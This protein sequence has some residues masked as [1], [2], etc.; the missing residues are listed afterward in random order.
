MNCELP[1]NWRAG[2]AVEKVGDWTEI[3]TASL[4]Y[5]DSPVASPALPYAIEL[6]DLPEDA[7]NVAITSI[8]ARWL[9][10]DAET[11]LAPVRPVAEP[12]PV[13]QPV[14]IPAP[15]PESYN[16][17][18][19]PAAEAELSGG[20]FDKGRFR[21]RIRFNPYRYTHSTLLLERAKSIKVTLSYESDARPRVSVMSVDAPPAATNM[22]IVSPPAY[23][24]LW[25][26]YIAYRRTTHPNI[27]ISVKNTADIYK[28]FPDAVAADDHA[29]AIHKFLEA[30]Y[31]TN[32]LKIVILGACPP[33]YSMDVAYSLD[34]FKAG[35]QKL[36]EEYHVPT[37][38]PSSFLCRIEEPSDLYFGCMDKNDGKEVWDSNGDHMYFAKADKNGIFVWEDNRDKYADLIPEL[39]VC[40]VSLTKE[41][42]ETSGGNVYRYTAAQQMTN[43]VEKIKY[44]ESKDWKGEGVHGLSGDTYFMGEGNVVSDLY[45]E[46][47]EFYDGA[48]NMGDAAFPKHVI[49]NEAFIR[50]RNYDYHTGMRASKEPVV[51]LGYLNATDGLYGGE[52]FGRAALVSEREARCA[53]HSRDMENAVV[54]SHGWMRSCNPWWS[55]G[56]MTGEISGKG[57]LLY[58]P[59]PCDSGM[60]DNSSITNTCC[61][62]VAATLAPSGFAASCGNTRHGWWAGFDNSYNSA[63]EKY[64]LAATFGVDGATDSFDAA[65]DAQLRPNSF[66]EA[67]RLM[68]KKYVEQYGVSV[69]GTHQ[70]ISLFEMTAFGDPLMSLTPQ[71]D[72]SDEFTRT[73]T[74][75]MTVTQNPTVSTTSHVARLVVESGA[76]RIATSDAGVLRVTAGA[77]IKGGSLDWAAAGGI[78][79]SIAFANPGGALTVSA[80]KPSYIGGEFTNVG[81]VKVTGKN[82]TIDFGV[83]SVNMTMPVDSLSF[84]SSAAGATNTLRNA[85]RTATSRFTDKTI[86]VTNSTLKCELTTAAPFSLKNSTLLVERNPMWRNVSWNE[87]LTMDDSTFVNAFDGFSFAN[88]ATINAIGGKNAIKDASGTGA[89]NVEGDL[90]VNLAAGAELTVECALQNL[91]THDSTLVV[92]GAGKIK[93]DVLPLKGF[94]SVTIGSGVTIEIPSAVKGR[95]RLIEGGTAAEILLLEGSTVVSGGVSK[96]SAS[97]FESYIFPDGHDGIPL[98]PYRLTLSSSSV[99]WLDS[100]DWTDKDGTKF[101]QSWRATDTVPGKTYVELDSETKECVLE[102][103]GEVEIGE[104]YITASDTGSS[105]AIASSGEF[106]ASYIDATG[107]AGALTLDCNLDS[108]SSTSL[109]AGP[110]TRFLGKGG[111]GRLTIGA[112]TKATLAKGWSGIVDSAG[113][114]VCEGGTSAD[115]AGFVPPASGMVVIAAPLAPGKDCTAAPEFTVKGESGVFDLSGHTLSV[116][117]AME[118]LDGAKLV[119]SNLTLSAGA[120]TMRID[121]GTLTLGGR[122]GA[123]DGASLSVA[124]SNGVFSAYES[125]SLDSDS[126]M[127]LEIVEGAK[128]T[129]DTAGNSISYPGVISGS[130]ALCVTNSASSY[131]TLVLGGANTYSGGTAIGGDL[132]VKA[133]GSGAFG[134]AGLLVL[135]EGVT[136]ELGSVRLGG[137]VKLDSSSKGTVTIALTEPEFSAKRA[138]LMK[139]DQAPE[140]M[141]FIAVS[142]TGSQVVGNVSVE[143]GNLVYGVESNARPITGKI[144]ENTPWTQIKWED[145]NGVSL[146]L[147][148]GQLVDYGE[149]RLVATVPGVF[150]TLDTSDLPERIV[151]GGAERLGMS[152]GSVADSSLPT[153]TIEEGTTVLF[154]DSVDWPTGKLVN[155]GIVRLVMSSQHTFTVG[156]MVSGRNAYS[157][158]KAGAQLTGSSGK[159]LRIEDGDAITVKD[160][161]DHD[162]GVEM[163]G[164]SILFDYYLDTAWIGNLSLNNSWTQSGGTA[165]FNFANPYIF[166]YPNKYGLLLGWTQSG[167][168]NVNI[169]GGN[170]NIPRSHINFW[171][172]GTTMTVSGMGVVNAGGILANG[173]GGRALNIRDGGEVR[174]GSLGA[175]SVS[176]TVTIDGGALVGTAQNTP[177]NCAI[178]VKDATLAATAGATLKLIGGFGTSSGTI[179][180][181][182]DNC[183]GTVDIGTLRPVDLVLSAS[184]L[185]TLRFTANTSELDR[186]IELFKAEDATLP[187]ALQVVCVDENGVE[188]YG[189][190]S[191]Y[192][193][194]IIFLKSGVLPYVELDGGTETLDG[195]TLYTEMGGKTGYEKWL[196]D[197]SY[198]G[199]KNY[200][201]EKLPEG[202][203]AHIEKMPSQGIRLVLMTLKP[204]TMWAG[205]FR[206]KWQTKG[207]WKLVP[208]GNQASQTGVAIGESSR[209]G[210][211][212]TN[213]VASL[214]LANGLN[215]AMSFTGAPANAAADQTLI[216][217]SQFVKSGSI[218]YSYTDS[219]GLTVSHSDGKIWG[220]Y[221]GN[222]STASSSLF[223][224]DGERHSLSAV[225]VPSS[226]WHGVRGYLDGADVVYGQ[227]LFANQSPANYLTLGGKTATSANN[228]AGVN[229]DMVAVFTNLTFDAD[230]AVAWKSLALENKTV[231][232]G[233]TLKGVYD[234][235]TF[236]N[237]TYTIDGLVLARAVYFDGDNVVLDIPEGSELRASVIHGEY[238]TPTDPPVVCHE[239]PVPD[240]YGMSFGYFFSGAVDGSWTNKQNWAKNVAYTNLSDLV[241]TDAYAP[242]T[243][244]G[245]FAPV[246]FDGERMSNTLA[247]VD[248]MKRITSPDSS[249]S[250]ERIEGW[251]LKLVLTNSVCVEIGR[252]RKLQPDT[253]IVVDETSRL[254]VNGFAGG[255]QDGYC[256]GNHDFFIASPS[257]LVFAAGFTPANA[258]GTYNYHLGTTG[259]VQYASLGGVASTH[260]IKSLTLDLGDPESS[261]TIVK[262]RKLVG[263]TANVGHTFGAADVAISSLPATNLTLSATQLS[264]ESA[265]G[266]YR[267]YD[268]DDGYYVEY[269]AYDGKKV[270]ELPEAGIVYRPT[271]TNDMPSGTWN[272]SF[273][274]DKEPFTSTKDGYSLQYGPDS[275]AAN[276]VLVPVV[277]DGQHPWFDLGARSGA[278]SFALYADIDAVPSNTRSV[279]AEFGKNTGM[280]AVLYRNTDLVS[281]AWFNGKDIVGTASVHEYSAG[282][283]LYVA[284]CDPSTGKLTL[285]KDGVSAAVRGNEGAVE[286]SNG[287]QIGSTFQGQPEGFG[288]ATGMAVAGFWGWDAA[289]SAEQIAHLA[290]QNPAKT[291]VALNAGSEVSVNARVVVD[292]PVD[293]IASGSLVDGLVVVTNSASGTFTLEGGTAFTVNGT[294]LADYTLT[295]NANAT[296]IVLAATAIE[297]NINLE[298]ET[299]SK[300]TVPAGTIELLAAAGAVQKTELNNVDLNGL[301]KW[302]NAM[303][304]LRSEQKTEPEDFRVTITM[305]NGKPKPESNASALSALSLDNPEVT[306]ETGAIKATATLQQCDSL[307]PSPAWGNASSAGSASAR[308]YRIRVS[309]GTE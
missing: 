47:R 8:E 91:A 162:I 131:G 171:G 2:E 145:A 305:V 174:I 309:F 110:D 144:S 111:K 188:V 242:A 121:A 195:A 212:V 93:F 29:L 213:T 165:T 99:N 164:G 189:S 27:G 153:L 6:I 25:D 96:S 161:K 210:V 224:T 248:G 140:G 303:L 229:L 58:G 211:I 21:Q 306:V 113:T 221:Q 42:V 46:E 78:G 142:P 233:T 52:R 143:D 207:D 271:S 50:K 4:L 15:D 98:P 284:V 251:E 55:A 20:F 150:V 232:P 102:A 155:N 117:G 152:K 37:R 81:S 175:Q 86:G 45:R 297:L 107:F 129:F 48:P 217:Y 307:S 115:W 279:L 235:L 185:G 264:T 268:A 126:I 87:P 199:D 163:A 41:L 40:R 125:W 94:K 205:D 265:I 187:N 101:T 100:S 244:D 250:G 277:V 53:L 286:L 24:N 112:E 308:F 17:A 49:D 104:L 35:M 214:P 298:G 157:N 73:L 168:Y 254:V 176:P 249:S 278:F 71:T 74:R 26:G 33:S 97:S 169:T 139:A 68:R 215:V 260:N 226:G 114:L 84:V 208:N 216:A 137:D 76:S 228:L 63:L 274:S 301:R 23:T 95:V 288:R 160:L 266:S 239:K 182:K 294:A 72:A 172:S 241:V 106:T 149:V 296:A 191:V 65:G 193:G 19:Y 56:F 31:A 240:A 201:I 287:F 238:R 134:S 227:Y 59:V 269:V 16:A 18:P 283:H 44:V 11:L 3:R 28:E 190:P 64:L 90:Q 9:T 206:S 38:Y 108:A 124:S 122:V 32:N 133:G 177:I 184:S 285:Y 255:D 36:D 130:G 119:A 280:K 183:V 166:D 257:G 10:A 51:Q 198:I 234:V 263:F 181:G 147:T 295:T 302:Q 196:V 261:G 138:V 259:S 158:A 167:T 267:F 223:P 180:F 54:D 80:T 154:N 57:R 256:N 203:Y 276:P 12:V 69:I 258:A 243:S 290:G 141:T 170:F 202:V 39:Q 22:V 159:I 34:Y 83:E 300:L 253:A 105:L 275:T 236:G 127:P 151:I 245:V 291:G 148:Y 66:G 118:I 270:V 304:G 7:R 128:H 156:S 200:V 246:I 30:E 82:A 67:I 88:A 179:T 252:L 273:G 192:N 197:M 132:L 186:A 218:A 60:F 281:L 262:T 225:V 237:G 293:V 1:G 123:S 103:D 79:R 272:M 135:G 120:S 231:I 209:G 292:G 220:V 116:G 289:L 299:P 136:L 13:P 282:Y 5:P 173:S 219:T 70:G 194:K 146:S 62:F 43:W 247:V 230:A 77:N 109:N 178:N 222:L 85:R 75:T 204:E 89:L 92:Y 61:V 14:V